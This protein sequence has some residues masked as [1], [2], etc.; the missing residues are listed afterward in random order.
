MSAST[1]GG[2]F[3]LSLLSQ[4]VAQSLNPVTVSGQASYTPSGADLVIKQTTDKLITN[5][6]QFGV[7]RGSSV[8]FEQPGSGSVA[9]NRVLGNQTSVIDG[10]LTSNGRVFI[11]NPNGVLFSSGAN[12]SV[13]S[14]VASSLAIQDEDFLRGNYRFTG[15]GTEGTVENGSR[16]VASIP[17]GSGAYVALISP[18]VKNTGTI[19]VGEGGT[20]A[21]GAGADVTL[22]VGGPVKLLIKAGAAEALIQNSG[23]VYAPGG[24]VALS[25]WGLSEAKGA[26]INQSGVLSA[27]HLAQGPGGTVM[28]VAKGGSVS[29]PGEVNA[30]GGTRG[31]KIEVQS[32]RV[33]VWPGG[34][35]SAVGRNGSGG[36]IDLRAEGGVLALYGQVDA[37]GATDGGQVLLRGKDVWLSA[38]TKVRAGGHKAQG[39][40]IGL[41]ADEGMAD[42]SGTLS[43]TGGTAGGVIE[44][45]A[46][47]VVL[48]GSS[49]LTV[50]GAYGDGGKVALEAAD[51]LRQAQGSVINATGND[52]G[53]VKIAAGG[54]LLLAGAALA[55]GKGSGSGGLVDVSA[56]GSL[57][58]ATR[59]QLQSSHRAGSGGRLRLT[60]PTWVV[61]SEASS[62]ALQGDQ[63]S[64][65]LSEGH[66]VQLRAVNDVQVTTG[67]NAKKQAQGSLA[68]TAGRSVGIDASVRA[69]NGDISI[70]ANAQD[71]DLQAGRG[72][73]FGHL[74]MGAQGG[75][76]QTLGK[77]ALRIEGN[78]AAPR[79]GDMT[80]SV[81]KA[82]E[83]TLDS[84]RF[85]ARGTVQDKVYDGSTAATVNGLQ[86][87]GLNLVGDTNLTLR[88]DLAFA[89]K[90]AGS[91]KTLSG[92]VVL[93]GFHHSDAERGATVQAAQQDIALTAQASI[94]KRKLTLEQLSAL[95]KTYD[96]STSATLTFGSDNRVDGDELTVNVEAAFGD[97]NAGANKAVRATAVELDGLDAG[98]YEVEL[99]GVGAAASI[100][101][102]TLNLSGLS[103]LDKTY[104]GL[105][106]ATVSFG[107][108]DRVSGD[109]LQYTATG[110]FNN[111]N[112]G[113]GKLVAVDAVDLTGADAGN[114]EVNHGNATTT[115]SIGQRVLTVAD[116]QA[117]N[118]IYDGTTRAD[119]TI[120]SDNRITGDDLRL[121]TTAHF[122]NKHAGTD[123]RV[124]V[125]DVTLSGEDAGNYQVN[126]VGLETSATIA[127]RALTLEQLVAQSKVYDGTVRANIASGGNDR[128]AGDDVRVSTTGQFADKHAGQNKTVSVTGVSL[129]GMDANNYEVDITGLQ[130]QANIDRRVLS[131]G[132]LLA[133]DKVYDGNINAD[134]SYGRNDRV[135]GDDI[136]VSASG[137]FENK[138]AGSNKRVTVTGV[139]LEGADAGNYVADYEGH[140]TTATIERRLLSLHDLK[141]LDKIYDGQVTASVAFERDDRVSGD[142]LRVSSTGRFDD[143]HAG[144]GKTVTITDVALTGADA[145]NYRV[146]AIGSTTQATV[147]QRQLTL[148][149][150]LAMDKVYDRNTQAAVAA[151]SDDRVLGDQMQVALTGEFDDRNAGRNKTVTV[152]G[153]KLS[154]DDARNY[155]VSDAPMTTQ[156]AITPRT[157]TVSIQAADKIYDGRTDAQISFQ[158]DRL[159]GDL[160]QLTGGSG[161]FSDANAGKGKVVTASE[162]QLVGSDAGNYV[163]DAPAWQTQ[164][165]I[166]PRQLNVSAPASIHFDKFLRPG[167]VPI[168]S[169]ALVG[170]DVTVVAGS[171]QWGRV[172]GWRQA[173]TLSDLRIEGKHAGNYVVEQPAL[174][175]AAIVDS[176]MPLPGGAGWSLCG[177]A[178]H[179]CRP[180]QTSHAGVAHPSSPHAQAAA[181]AASAQRLVVRDG[182]IH[183]PR[184]QLTWDGE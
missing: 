119:V 5:W 157:L 145:G 142:D 67:V 49:V 19:M 131:L 178:Q 136:R 77:V 33:S 61:G 93:T 25:A 148:S 144:I 150:L 149:Q 28:L 88:T 181:H 99:D 9:L 92:G 74:R 35:L 91:N 166:T 55:T 57:G 85:R 96:G 112:A 118:R 13:G 173:L 95:D 167:A 129:D 26:I 68:I 138:N 163:L 147:A 176:P 175:L 36:S 111:K 114:Y 109:D 133:Q 65:W 27:E 113:S 84:V 69:G 121:A 75:E 17:G 8:V 152:T 154:G 81:V 41:T 10:T 22:D 110:Q 177:A 165:S 4:A 40:F 21:M 140:A 14:L 60:A 120:G 64:S 82:S 139:V 132:A 6:D 87:D 137:R 24:H 97:K 76:L 102:R 169:D 2:L 11:V 48:A 15:N 94:S 47:E 141:A 72:H 151:G 56:N 43:A 135:A 89:D 12:V 18:Q 34:R 59:A 101:K 161:H 172:P 134:V 1:F 170:D 153:V 127:K 115:A 30:S 39:G 105:R 29:L 71:Q 45:R 79:A 20:V 106:E 179:G 156:A 78:E 123:K 53:Q 124:T 100:F 23:S 86:V 168:T 155:F 162:W 51:S 159:A 80:L 125:S 38:D 44:V 31:G 50:A 171:A 180:S 7:R 46:K 184:E 98:N 63:V 158:D 160:L 58:V 3:A 90:H 66:E 103:A 117:M 126:T 37:S 32:E 146:E 42:T 122:D 73:G 108:D 52:G 54:D 174:T 182:G 143:K 183:A 16:I 116:L 164:A 104:D 70:V 130:A 128:L 83:L 62:N 107:R